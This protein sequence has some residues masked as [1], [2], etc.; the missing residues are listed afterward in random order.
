M[1]QMF[2]AHSGSSR[3]Q[4]VQS[5]F[6]ELRKGSSRLLGAIALL[7]PHLLGEI[8]V[9][10][11]PMGLIWA[12]L[13]LRI[14]AFVCMTPKLGKSSWGSLPQPSL[15]HPSS[16]EK[17]Q[18]HRRR[19]SWPTTYHDGMGSFPSPSFENSCTRHHNHRP[20]QVSPRNQAS[21]KLG[22]GADMQGGV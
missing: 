11:C 15:L 8:Q 22:V 21:H 18:R 3:A 10:R 4:V 19:P 6:S 14:P 2:P 13:S 12:S 1:A 7:S 16:Y 20:S 17:I 9:I 5:C